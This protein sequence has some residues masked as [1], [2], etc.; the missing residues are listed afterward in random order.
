MAPTD[1]LRPESGREEEQVAPQNNPLEWGRGK[2]WILTTIIVMMT[3]TIAFCSSVYT[4]AIP[5]IAVHLQCSETVSTLGVTTFLLGFGSGPLLFAPLSEIVGRNPVY[6]V[7]FCLFVLLQLACALSPNITSLLVFRFFSGFFGSP[8]VT[9]SGGSL[10]DLWA[11][12]E[13]TVPLALFSA[14]SFLG[15]VIAPTVGGFIAQYTSWHWIFW[16][17]LI[18]GGS[19]YIIMFFLLPETYAPRL[20]QD[21]ARQSSPTPGN[22]NLRAQ[23]AATLTR[24]WLMFFT[25]PILFLLSLYMALVYGI[26]Y[27]DFT[28]YPIVFT[29]SRH[30][31]VG[32]S[33]LSFLGIG[34]GMAIATAGSPYLNRIHARY[35]RKLGPE[36]EARLPHLIILSWAIPIGLFWFAWTSLP[37]THWISSI[38][39]GVPFGLGL[40]TLFLGIT[41]YLTDCYGLYSASALAANAILRSLFGAVF[42][43]FAKQMYAS[44][45][46]PWA[47]SLLG[48]LAVAMAPLPLFFYTLGPKLR[49]RSKFHLRTIAEQEQVEKRTSVTSV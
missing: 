30:W 9:N 37:P 20:L 43:L 11:P 15:P 26:L 45:G 17:V 24:P 35:V 33:G 41:A 36:P 13:R 19:V 28:A 34:V 16:V 12:S 1:T 38:I 42:P 3:A 31:S 47:T 29:Q 48:F 49:Q 23:Y 32:V 25:E 14:A 2:K 7:T 46:T 4:A 40:V 22:T 44:L 18:L 39:A 21:A 5:T 27:L 6:R 8:T 10:T